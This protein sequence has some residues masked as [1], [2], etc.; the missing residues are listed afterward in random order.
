MGY[1]LT[2]DDIGIYF[3]DNTKIVKIKNSNNFVYI[4]EQGEQIIYH[5]KKSKLDYDL[6]TKVNAL[7]LFYREFNKNSINKK[8]SDKNQKI[9][10]ENPDLFVKKWIKSQYAYFFLLSNDK[11]QIIFEDKS[12]II[13]DFFQKK[14][15]FINKM[16]EN[17]IYNIENTRFENESIEQKVKYV[18]RILKKIS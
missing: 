7:I 2:N 6:K 18:K 10:K 5:L 12:Q 17:S 3:N 14:I 1:L 9:H 13:F 8:G 16:K 11:V 4:N 15:C